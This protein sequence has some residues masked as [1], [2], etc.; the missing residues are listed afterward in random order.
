MS[1]IYSK[2]ARRVKELRQKSGISQQRLAE[3]L[4]ISR[5]TISQIENRERKIS[6]D[7]LIKISDIFNTHKPST[8]P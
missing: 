1:E 6:A 3:L 8:Y 7:E 5:P 2:L 4:K